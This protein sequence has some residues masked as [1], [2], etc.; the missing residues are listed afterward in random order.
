MENRGARNKVTKEDIKEVLTY[1]FSPTAIKAY[2]NLVGWYVHDHI[3]PRARMRFGGNSRI[4]PSASFRS[5]NNIYLGTNSHISQYCCIWAGKNSQIVLGNNLL[6]GP[7]VKIFSSNHGKDLG[8]P[9]NSQ[10]YVEKDVIVG[11]DVWLG[12]N[13]VIVPG[14]N[15]GEGAIVAAGSVATRNVEPYTFVGGGSCESSKKAYIDLIY[16][17]SLK[18]PG[19]SGGGSLGVTILENAPTLSGFGYGTR[20]K[21]VEIP[22]GDDAVPMVPWPCAIS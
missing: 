17:S 13:A 20:A 6:M 18:F 2:A 21:S 9:M 5:G 16:C 3:A 4:H 19:G 15:I 10:V 1:L 12:A 7:G 8:V 14:V 11:N 22:Y